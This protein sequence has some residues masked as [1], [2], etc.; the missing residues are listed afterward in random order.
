MQRFRLAA[1]FRLG[2]VEFCGIGL[3]F[4]SEDYVIII[5]STFSTIR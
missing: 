3:K 1:K 5:E 2:F 4:F